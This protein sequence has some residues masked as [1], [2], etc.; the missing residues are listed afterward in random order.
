MTKKPNAAA[1]IKAAK[2]PNDGESEVEKFTP[3]KDPSGLLSDEELKALKGEIQAGI[4]VQKSDGRLHAW[5]CHLAYLNC[6]W[7]DIYDD[8]DPDEFRCNVNS[9]FANLQT[10]IP[11]L[12]FQQPTVNVQPAKAFFEVEKT[13]RLGQ[14][15]KVRVDNIQSAKLFEKRLN[16]VLKN[17]K[18]EP[19]AERWIA[20]CLT[21][22]GYGVLKVGVGFET[23]ARHDLS[24]K[25]GKTTFWARRV[26]PR[27]VFFDALASY[28]GDRTMTFEK[29]IRRKADLLKDPR[30]IRE[31]VMKMATKIPDFLKS[32]FDKLER[33]WDPGLVEF[34]EVHNERTRTVR[35]ISLEGEVMEIRKPLKK[36]TWI[37]G[38]DYITLSLNIETDDAIYPLSDSMP[39]IDQAKARNR[40]RTAQVKF[41]ENWGTT[42]FI[43]SQFFDSDEAEE[44][45]RKA[46]NGTTVVKVKTGAI[47]GNKML[48]APPPP[49]PRDW[50]AMDDVFRRDNDETLGISEYMR[51]QAGDASTKATTVQTVQNASNIRIARRRRRIKLALLE[52]AQKIGAL[53]MEHDTDGASLDLGD[54]VEDEDFVKFLSEQYGFNKDVP[55]LNVSKEMYQGEYLYDFEIEEMLERPKSVQVQQLLSTI[56]TLGKNPIFMRPLMEESDPKH[57]V[58]TIFELQGMHVEGLRKSKP[59]AQFPPELENEM[60]ERG[61]DIPPPHPKDDDDM[62]EF[63]HLKL[64]R[65]M[66]ARL[67]ALLRGAATQDPEAVA[68]YLQVKKSI[69]ILQRH[70][71]AHEQKKLMKAQVDQLLG[72]GGSGGPLPPNGPS[73]I[74]GITPPAAPAAPSEMQINQ[75]AGGGLGA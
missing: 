55:F 60:A 33:K 43:E 31:K 74:Q 28:F 75:N 64:E 42:A 65:E 2:N 34:F 7:D 44:T 22:Y 10:E 61:I 19:I 13:D 41:L 48:V 27:N 67:P 49:M 46:G 36:K 72:A 9:I 56:D 14:P 25:V 59:Q 5:E 4:D 53:I 54:A 68:A 26:D 12:Y 57:V 62:H 32:R 24:Q 30:Y 58:R 29:I 17:M 15:I 3:E 51:G 8:E 47:S 73:I 35:W 1:E 23:E 71:L 45:W 66:Q 38:S 11:T 50:F 18:L 70:A 16:N 63:T 21:P 52:L 39:I 37:E 6:R 69:E 20:D 40:V